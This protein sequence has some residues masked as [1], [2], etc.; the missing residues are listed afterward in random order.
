MVGLGCAD[1]VAEER[2]AGKRLRLELRV[3]LAAEKPRMVLMELD[4]LDELL[5]RRHPGERQAVL[6]Q[7]R[8]ELLVHLEAVAVAVPGDGL[9]VGARREGPGRELRRI[10]AEAHRAAEGF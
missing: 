2:V 5:V 3:E 7:G 4:D 6:L 1:E 8:Q 10:L 9:A